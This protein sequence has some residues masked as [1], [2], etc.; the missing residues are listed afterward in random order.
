[1]L[2]IVIVHKNVST[3]ARVFTYYKVSFTL[4]KTTVCLRL[5]S[6]IAPISCSDHVPQN[7]MHS[8]QEKGDG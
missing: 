8:P 1:M 5:Y 7:L 4:A 3:S 6:Y 2:A